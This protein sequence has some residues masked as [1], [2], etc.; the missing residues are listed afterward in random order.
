VRLLLVD[1]EVGKSWRPVTA[2]EAVG[3]ADMRSS[4]SS[5]LALRFRL[6]ILSLP[7]PSVGRVSMSW[8]WRRYD[9]AG[10]TYLSEREMVGV[11]QGGGERTVGSTR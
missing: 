9:A 10:R 11:F 8:A 6:D 7:K 5:S 4:R 3:E 1:L 2:G